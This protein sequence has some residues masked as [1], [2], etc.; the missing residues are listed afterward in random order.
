MNET[1]SWVAFHSRSKCLSKTIP[2][3][4]KSGLKSRPDLI[5]VV[6][7]AFMFTLLRGSRVRLEFVHVM[8]KPKP[9]N[10]LIH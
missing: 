3:K 4:A 8:V 5:Q 1:N 9:F 2:G 10:P 6:R 7:T